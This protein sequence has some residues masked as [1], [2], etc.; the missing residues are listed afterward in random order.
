MSK[1]FDPKDVYHLFKMLFPAANLPKDKL[2]NL[3]RE[4][5]RSMRKIYIFSTKKT[6]RPQ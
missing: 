4:S 2:Q 3:K 1:E 5:W 6:M